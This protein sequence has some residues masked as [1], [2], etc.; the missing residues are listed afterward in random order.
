MARLVIAQLNA[1]AAVIAQN[2]ARAQIAVFVAL[3]K[4]VAIGF[5]NRGRFGVGGVFLGF[6][7]M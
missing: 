4:K 3:T 7:G 6:F 5:F 1:I 2:E